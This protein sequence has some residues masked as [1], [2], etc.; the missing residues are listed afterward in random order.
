MAARLIDPGDI[1]KGA[2]DIDADPPRDR[3]TVLFRRSRLH[4]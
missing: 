3:D 2:A 4:R 1:G